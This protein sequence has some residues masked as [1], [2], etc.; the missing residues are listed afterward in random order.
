MSIENLPLIKLSTLKEVFQHT[1]EASLNT[2]LVGGF[3]EPFYRPASDVS[4][5]QIQFRSDYVSSAL[6]ELAHWCVAGP[7][8]RQREDYGYWY[9][10]D[11]RNETQQR[12]FAK[13]ESRPQ[14][15]E[16]YLSLALGVP[17]RVSADNL[18]GP[19]NLD[20]LKRS[21]YSEFE[22]IRAG[23]I[24]PRGR[25]LALALCAQTEVD[26]EREM[27]RMTLHYLDHF[28]ESPQ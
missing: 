16:W 9:A 18:D 13:V 27:H 11:G 23:D 26:V 12:E 1:F 20:D 7:E 22:R 21:V 28:W 14:A 8:R 25:Q 4:P 10:P 19:V 17:F 3:D 5:A 6:H 2:E 15:V 24:P